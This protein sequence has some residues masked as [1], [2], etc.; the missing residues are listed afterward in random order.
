MQNLFVSD[1]LC[2]L[3]VVS[4]VLRVRER[5]RERLEVRDT[6]STSRLD[7]FHGG[8]LLPEAVSKL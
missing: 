7:A 4:V 6:G 3:F 5:E 1:L 8:F 2:P